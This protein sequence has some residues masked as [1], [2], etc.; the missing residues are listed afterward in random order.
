MV[1]ASACGR[2][3][4]SVAE[5]QPCAG[6]TADAP[7][8]NTA[9]Q[10]ARLQHKAARALRGTVSVPSTSNSAITFDELVISLAHAASRHG[11]RDVDDPLRMRSAAAPDWS[12]GPVVRAVYR[13]SGVRGTANLVGK[14]QP[15]RHASDI[16][17]RAARCVTSSGELWSQAGCTCSGGERG[18]LVVASARGRRARRRLVDAQY[19]TRS[20]AFASAAVAAMP[21]VPRARGETAAAF[22]GLLRPLRRCQQPARASAAQPR[23]SRCVPR[24]RAAPQAKA[25]SEHPPQLG[26]PAQPAERSPPA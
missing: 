5:V 12:A 13:L 16:T 24:R 7:R 1:S 23:H 22:A 19:Q 10:A 26:V 15:R 21:A 8:A 17:S 18:A 14:T 2:L 6:R 3:G 9:S 20:A 4:A 25:A 11:W